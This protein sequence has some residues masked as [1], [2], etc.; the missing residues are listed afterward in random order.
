MRGKLETREAQAANERGFLTTHVTLARVLLVQWVRCLVL[1][2][3]VLRCFSS[4][5]MF[6]SSAHEYNHINVCVRAI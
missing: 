3:P 1:A 5:P 4:V 2:G 6:H